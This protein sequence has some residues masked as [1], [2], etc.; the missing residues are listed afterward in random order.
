M[1]LNRTHVLVMAAAL[2]AGVG[3]CSTHSLTSLP[4]GQQPKLTVTDLERLAAESPVHELP[5]PGQ[6]L[7]AA[8][9]VPIPSYLQDA[10]SSSAVTQGRKPSSFASGETTN[11]VAQMG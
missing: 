6:H 9:G 5:V 3:G 1:S 7:N 4:F 10:L 11:L 8:P 2:L